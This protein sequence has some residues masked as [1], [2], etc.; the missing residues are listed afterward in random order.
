MK[1]MFITGGKN[2]NTNNDLISG[3]GPDI[4]ADIWTCSPDIKNYHDMSDILMVRRLAVNEFANAVG[5][6]IP[7]HSNIDLISGPYLVTSY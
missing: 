1:K 3:K 2:I 4:K 6:S 7:S 5:G